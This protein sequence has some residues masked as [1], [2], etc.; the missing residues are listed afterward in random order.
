MTYANGCTSNQKNK[1]TQVESIFQL[2]TKILSNWQNDQKLMSL[3]NFAQRPLPSILKDL[4]GCW[5]FSMVNV[6]LGEN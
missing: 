4:Q 1:F 6:E 3:E 2:P 5:G